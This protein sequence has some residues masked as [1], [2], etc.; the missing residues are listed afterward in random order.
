MLSTIWLPKY[1]FFWYMPH[2][3]IYLLWTKVREANLYWFFC[4]FFVVWSGLH[5]CRRERSKGRVVVHQQ[6]VRSGTESET[7]RDLVQ[8]FHFQ[9]GHQSFETFMQPLQH[10][11]SKKL[12][13]GPKRFAVK[14]MLKQATEACKE[15]VCVAK[16]TG[17]LTDRF[18]SASKLW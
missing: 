8:V 15:I 6:K 17:M 7:V 4:A 12:G 14:H 5:P 9:C 16:Q 10:G 2:M 1:F 18:L 3:L 13:Y 11:N